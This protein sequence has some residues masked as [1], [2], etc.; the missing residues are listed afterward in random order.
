VTS[1]DYG[2]SGLLR[3]ERDDERGVV[4]ITLDAPEK[5]NRVPLVARD[6]IASLFDA[7][8]TTCSSACPRSASG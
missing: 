3:V 4:T 2:E 5:L 6:E 7:L 8:G 1:G